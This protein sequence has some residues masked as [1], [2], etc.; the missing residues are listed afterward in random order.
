MARSAQ[1]ILALLVL[2]MV[3]ARNQ[4]RSVMIDGQD[5]LANANVQA[6]LSMIRRFE[7]NG[8]YN[9]L[10]GGDHFVSYAQ[11][12]QVRVPFFNPKTQKNDYSTA[13]GAYQIN[14]PTWNTILRH[15]GNG[16]FSPASQDAAA[17][18]LLKLN[19]ALP[20]IMDGDFNS[21]IRKASATWA[22]L[23]FTDSKQAH[24]SMQM[25]TLAYTNAGGQIA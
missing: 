19:G 22:S 3:A 2:A 16:D 8:D 5:A 1:L 17:V 4:I 25:A 21:A 14:W 12:P 6:F 10:Y 9:V 11:H 24:V 20:D 13:A 23:P 18:W 15:A 7:S